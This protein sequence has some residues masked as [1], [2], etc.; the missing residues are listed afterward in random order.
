MRHGATHSRLIANNLLYASS[1]LSLCCLSCFYCCVY[2]PRTAENFR[3]LCTGAKGFGY[4]GSIFH[5][6]ITN[7]MCQGGGTFAFVFHLCSIT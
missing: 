3:Q 1:R 6:V 4:K 5:R 7:F 2:S